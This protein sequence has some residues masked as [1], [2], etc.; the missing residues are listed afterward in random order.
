MGDFIMPLSGMDISWKQKLNRDTGKLT[1]VMNPNGFNRYYTTFHPK[2][3]E[4]TFFSATHGTFSKK[5]NTISCQTGFHRYKKTNTI[6]CILSDYHGL[7]LVFNDNKNNRNPTYKWK[8]NN[9]LLNINM[10]KEEIK[11]LETF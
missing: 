10:V 2:K 7:R 1:E 5:D 8:M 6:S 9:T 11:K 4:Y 3:Q